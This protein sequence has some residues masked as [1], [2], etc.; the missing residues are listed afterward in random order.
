MEEGAAQPAAGAGPGLGRILGS[1]ADPRGAGDSR[2]PGKRSV[3]PWPV[4]GS[5]DGGGSGCPGSHGCVTAL[6]ED[7]QR[8]IGLVAGV[9][10]AGH[11]QVVAGSQAAAA[12]HVAA[13][14]EGRAVGSQQAR[15]E[16]ATA[17]GVPQAQQLGGRG[18]SGM[19]TTRKR[20][21]PALRPTAPSQ[22]APS[23]PT[24][25]STT[26]A[27]PRPDAHT[28]APRRLPEPLG[29]A[30]G[31]DGLWDLGSHL[32]PTSSGI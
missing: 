32:R 24:G 13:G 3:G 17:R 31:A 20:I 22:G 5:R 16:L 4:W 28:P 21:P 26:Q 14:A 27:V 15:Q 23:P 18:G 11:H 7:A 10:G 8:K 1:C 25:A 12:A 29:L 9:G 19:I 6:R 2:G 30:R